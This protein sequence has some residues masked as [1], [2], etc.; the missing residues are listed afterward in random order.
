MNHICQYKIFHDPRLT[1]GKSLRLILVVSVRCRLMMQRFQYLLDFEDIN[2]RS[3]C[4]P[5]TYRAGKPNNG[6]CLPRKWRNKPANKLKSAK[7]TKENVAEQNNN[8]ALKK[9]YLAIKKEKKQTRM[10]KTINQRPFKKLKVSLRLL[11]KKMMERR[12]QTNILLRVKE[13]R[14]PRKRGNLRP[15]QLWM[16]PKRPQIKGIWQE[17]VLPLKLASS[18]NSSRSHISCLL[19]NVSIPFPAIFYNLKVV[20]FNLVY[21]GN[22][23]RM[24]ISHTNMDMM[25]KDFPC[26]LQAI[27][28]WFF[29][30]L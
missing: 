23:T 26:T 5:R 21:N 24:H 22:I 13:E 28:L 20:V 15:L 7:R 19:S 3:S 4:L 18:M 14:N 1:Y 12:T 27:K 6:F 9:S 10:E 25:L 29:I 30:W 11:K 8:V 17:C 2:L 16:L